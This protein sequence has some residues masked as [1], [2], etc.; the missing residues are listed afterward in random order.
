MCAVVARPCFVMTSMVKSS[1]KMC[2]NV[3]AQ[4]EIA[5]NTKVGVFVNRAS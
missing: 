3:L 5:N 1:R 2:F 4:E